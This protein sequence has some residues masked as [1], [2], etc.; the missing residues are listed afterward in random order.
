MSFKQKISLFEA[1]MLQPFLFRI[2]TFKK[3]IYIDKTK[4]LL[5]DLGISFIYFSYQF[6]Y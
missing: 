3:E 1:N 2:N 4:K 5:T 6:R